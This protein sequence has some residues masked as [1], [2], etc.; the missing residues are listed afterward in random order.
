M[1]NI[2]LILALNFTVIDSAI[3]WKQH[4]EVEVIKCNW[5]VIRG[6][7]FKHC[8]NR[9]VPNY[10]WIRD[11]QYFTDHMGCTHIHYI[12]TIVDHNE[13]IRSS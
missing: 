1:I 8:D 5:N 13:I 11:V 3:Y 12:D 10:Y 9:P 2:V 6:K 4:N 7:L